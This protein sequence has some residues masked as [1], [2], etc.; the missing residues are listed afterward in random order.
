MNKTKETKDMYLVVALNEVA[1]Y[2]KEETKEKLKNLPLSFQY[3]I[4]KNM[5]PLARMADDFNT[6]KTEKEQSLKDK[7]FD[8]EHS[9]PTKIK[10]DNGDEIDARKIKEEFL[11]EYEGEVKQLNTQLEKLL[12]ETDEISF[13]PIDLDSLVEAAGD[14][15]IT[16]EDV[17]MISIFEVDED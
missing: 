2:N 4:R 16:M 13:T 10:D 6:F 7:W 3:T 8:E 15:S 1:W 14:D 11:E 9:D 17:D 5:K 12:S